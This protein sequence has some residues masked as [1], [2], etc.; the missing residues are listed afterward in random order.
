MWGHSEKTDVYGPGSRPSPDTIS[1][2]ILDFS[3]SN[4]VK[5]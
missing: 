5:K 1:T 3:A 2:L 4:T